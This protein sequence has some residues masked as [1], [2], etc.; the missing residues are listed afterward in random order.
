MTT[1]IRNRLDE[2]ISYSG[3]SYSHIIRFFINEKFYRYSF[4]HR[5]KNHHSM[6]VYI[7]KPNFIED[8]NDDEDIERDFI[9]LVFRKKKFDKTLKKTKRGQYLIDS[10]ESSFIF[11]RDDNRVKITQ[12]N[13]LY[14]NKEDLKPT[15][16]IFKAAS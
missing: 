3:D 15:E 14:I 8:M 7:G 6:I 10:G 2:G 11:Y 4:V 5:G 16:K 1:A 12:N 9:K 13:K